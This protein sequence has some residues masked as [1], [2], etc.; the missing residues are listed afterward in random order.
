MSVCNVHPSIERIHQ[1]NCVCV[2]VFCTR[3]LAPIEP[4]CSTYF[5]E[6]SR[7]WWCVLST[8][9]PGSCTATSLTMCWPVWRPFTTWLKKVRLRHRWVTRKIQNMKYIYIYMCSYVLRNYVWLFREKE[10]HFRKI[11]TQLG[12]EERF[13]IQHFMSTLH[14][15]NKIIIVHTIVF[16]FGFVPHIVRLIVHL[17]LYRITQHKLHKN[18]F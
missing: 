18:K 11:R 8:Q 9:G 14:I 1:F 12:H 15:M 10:R 16:S 7:P 13:M 17:A 4:T 3:C 5:L 2:C 6:R